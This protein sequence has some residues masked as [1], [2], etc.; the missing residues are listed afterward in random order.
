MEVQMKRILAL[1]ILALLVFPFFAGSAVRAQ[2]RNGIF[3]A[4]YRWVYEGPGDS[5]LEDADTCDVTC[6]K[7]GTN[8]DVVDV[9][10]DDFPDLNYNVAR[11]STTPP[12]G[13]PINSGSYICI[14]TKVYG[15]Q[16][17]ESDWTSTIDYDGSEDE[18]RYVYL[19]NTGT[20][21]E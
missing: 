2:G 21:I 6:R 7:V 1:T 19:K 14:A 9:T 4:C 3:I 10:G 17:W 5:T 11:F 15:T 20:T 12:P 16:I 13:E 18:S 8:D